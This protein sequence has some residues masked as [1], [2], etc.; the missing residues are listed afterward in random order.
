MAGKYRAVAYDA[1]GHGQSDVGDAQYTIELHVDDLIA[2]LD[3]LKIEKAVLVGLS[4]GGY[5]ALRALERN[6]ER[7]RA[8]VLCDT[9]SEAD[10]NEA[11]LKRAA[12]IANVKK[13]GA[14]VFAAEFVKGVFTAETLKIKPEVVDQIRNTIARMSPLAITGTLLALAARTDTTESL[15]RIKVPSMILV[16]EHDTITPLSA[17]QAMHERIPNA[18]LHVIPRSAHMSSLENPEVFNEKLLSFLRR[19]S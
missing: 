12:G 17:A 6:P 1:R 9:R 14:A 4:M 18:E 13:N 5:I 2:L 10:S 19:V 3:H 8:A 15:S 7:V 11:R 16:G